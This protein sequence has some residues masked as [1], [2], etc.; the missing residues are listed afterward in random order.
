MISHNEN[1][2][3]EGGGQ[4]PYRQSTKSLALPASL[5]DYDES[6]ERG[7]IEEIVNYCRKSWVSNNLLDLRN[8]ALVAN[9][10]IQTVIERKKFQGI[11]YMLDYPNTGTRLGKIVL[12]PEAAV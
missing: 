2:S 6:R 9:Q 7:S 3:G 11:Q 8:L 1:S 4:G 10:S 12:T 5:A